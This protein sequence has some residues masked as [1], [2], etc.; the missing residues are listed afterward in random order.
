[1]INM[2]RYGTFE[3]PEIDI[4]LIDVPIAMF[5]GKQDTLA[6]PQ[7]NLENKKKIQKNLIHYEVY[8]RLDH[9]AFILGRDMKYFKDVVST[10]EK[11]Y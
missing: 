4:S 9:L 1:M 11:L 3:P 8:D 5:I 2:G 6:T 7:D 10:L